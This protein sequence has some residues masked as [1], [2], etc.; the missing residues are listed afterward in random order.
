MAIKISKDHIR[1]EV[2]EKRMNLSLAEAHQKNESIF[3]KVIA[4]NVFRQAEC[5]YCYVSLQQEVSTIKLID[6]ALSIGKS[7]AVPR[8]DG[9]NMD[10][11]YI[12][13]MDDLVPGCMKILE[14]KTYCQPA[15]EKHALVILPGLAFDN[16]GNRIGYGGGYYDR[17]LED[18]P[19]SF[20]LGVAFDFQ[21]YPQLPY[22]TF[23]C[24]VDQV[25]VND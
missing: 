6:Y 2:K 10:F 4:S 11:Y 24:L 16:A 17:Y 15:R 9:R 22:E 20:K 7:V 12:N 8:V 14:P 3:H 23:D 13:S 5:I 19:D 21:M 18:K 25:I 1:K